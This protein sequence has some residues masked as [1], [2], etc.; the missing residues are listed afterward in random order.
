MSYAALMGLKKGKGFIE[1]KDK[2]LLRGY[3][4]YIGASQVE[5]LKLKAHLIMRLSN[6]LN[7]ET[8]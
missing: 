7:S 4:T 2:P 8:K 1:R 6:A 3:E 5:G